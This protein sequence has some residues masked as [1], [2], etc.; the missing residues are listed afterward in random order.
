MRKVATWMSGTMLVLAMASWT[1]GVRAESEGDAASV[2]DAQAG[3]VTKCRQVGDVAGSDAIF[4]GL[5]AKK[6]SRRAKEKAVKQAAGLGADAVVWSQQGTSMTNEWIGKAYACGPHAASTSAKPSPTTAAT[7]GAGAN[8]AAAA[9]GEIREATAGA[10]GR[11]RAVGDIAG[12]DAIFVG[13]MAKKG[14]R[15]AKEKALK[16]AGELGADTVVWAQQGTSMT[17]EW[18]GKA[19]ACGNHAQGGGGKASAPSSA[20]PRSEASAPAAGGAG[21][22]REVM[23]GDVGRCRLLGDINGSNAVFVGLTAKIGSRKAKAQA[24]EKAT[25]MGADSVVWSQQ[26]TSMTNEWI[27]KAYRCK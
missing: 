1:D 24:L 8:A 14:S 3:E 27:G 15:R 26:G 11:C 4:V 17:N 6:G 13:L 22:I 9:P 7:S 10:V 25:G 21:A 16:Q 12:S 2:R 5:S 20:A 18:T 23:A 19:Y